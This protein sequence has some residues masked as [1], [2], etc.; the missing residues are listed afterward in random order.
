M[1]VDLR[2]AVTGNPLAAVLSLIL[3]V[4][5]ADDVYRLLTEYPIGVDLEIPLRAA[6]RWL[7]G[8]GPYPAAAFQASSGPDLPF[9]YPPFGLPFVAPL[10]LL[11]RTLVF[12][13]WM[14]T[15]V[16]VAYVS[17]RGL[18][19]GPL[20]SALI[21]FWPPYA[22]A[23]VGGNI[24]ILLFAAFVMVMF[25]DGRQLDP[26]DCVRPAIVDGVLSAFA[27]A[28]KVS[29]VHA[30]LYVLRRR[31]SA[32]LLGLGVFGV[33]ALITLPLV[34]TGVWF[35]WLSQAGRSGDP[36]WIYIGA[37][38]STFVG[39][40]LALILSVISIALV[41]VVPPRHAAAWIGILSLVGAPS[42][43]MFA[44]L[45]LLPAMRLVR[46]E[47]ALVAAILISTYVGAY[48]WIAVLVVSWAL[49]AMGRW[50]GLLAVRAITP[51]A[52][53]KVNGRLP[54]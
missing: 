12:I 1:R 39:Q 23:L 48:I 32:A 40:P 19:F 26:R 42:L 47:I 52:S 30:W 8:S 18:G 3:A 28:L 4:L 15:L 29:Q 25:R 6:E 7:A 44:L 38:V 33:I 35:D 31:P 34:G 14:L 36:T 50:P 11:P 20:V 46:L 45:F 27:G 2:R 22:E 43:H 13:P 51:E 16:I 49:L 24:Q 21:L 53:T 37:P 54:A 41:F 17:A 5:V 10:T 9:L